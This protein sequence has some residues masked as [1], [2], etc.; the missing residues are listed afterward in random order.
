MNGYGLDALMS[1]LPW[2][3]VAAAVGA[4]GALFVARWYFNRQL[5]AM[6][7]QLGRLGASRNLAEELLVQA[8]RQVQSL[9]DQDRGSNKTAK[10]MA[11]STAAIRK[12]LWI[13]VPDVVKAR[14][15][16]FADTEILE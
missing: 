10:P 5:E 15:W 11:E 2:L 13:D 14:E 12:A 3:G 16:A 8:R 7:M 6:R 4:V 1:M 9:Q